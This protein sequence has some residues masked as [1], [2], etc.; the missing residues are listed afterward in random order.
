MARWLSTQ[1]R[2]WEAAMLRD[3]MQAQYRA[4]PIPTVLMGD[5]N[6]PI[7]KESVNNVLTETFSDSVTELQLKDGWHLQTGS[8]LEVR[9]RLTTTFLQERAGLHPAFSRV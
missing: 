1:Q 2:G 5:M 7:S 4:H 3:A 9:L 6:Q 8:S